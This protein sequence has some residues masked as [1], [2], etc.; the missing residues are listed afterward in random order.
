[1]NQNSKVCNFATYFS[2]R[3]GIFFLS[4]FFFKKTYLSMHVGLFLFKNTSRISLIAAHYVHVKDAL[5]PSKKMSGALWRSPQD[6]AVVLSSKGCRCGDFSSFFLNPCCPTFFNRNRKQKTLCKG[7]KESQSQSSLR[8]SL[9]V[10]MKLDG[11]E[12]STGVVVHI[13]CQAYS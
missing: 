9:K 10:E 6:G 3:V 12:N 8:A 2:M 1:M 4:F 13:Q 5:M 7:A 11:K